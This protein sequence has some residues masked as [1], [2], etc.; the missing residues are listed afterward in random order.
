[1]SKSC[2]EVHF[3]DCNS[4]CECYKCQKVE[5]CELCFVFGCSENQP[6][7]EDGK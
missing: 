7:E 6:K 4:V 5:T 3:I 1:M 2:A